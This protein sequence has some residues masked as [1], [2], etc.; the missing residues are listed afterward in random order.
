MMKLKW[1]LSTRVATAGFLTP[2]MGLLAIFVVFPI[3][4]TAWMSLHSGSMITSYSDMPWVGLKNYAVIFQQP[5]FRTALLNT[6]LYSLVS[7]LIIVPLSV[8]LGIFL[9]QSTI[10]GRGV[11][12][13]LLFIPYVIPNVAIAIVW[14]Y[15]YAPQYGPFNQILGWFHI[16][17]QDWL[18]SVH[19]A[20]FALIILNVWQTLGYYVVLVV[21]GLTEIPRDYYEAASIDGASWLQQQLRLT[22]PLL[23]RSLAFIVVILTINTLQVFDPVYVLTQGG[24]IDA[25]NVVAFNMYQTAFNFGHAGTASAMAMVLLAVVLLLSLAQLRLFRS[26]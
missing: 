1:R 17:A 12:R 8:I 4:L 11:L 14:G 24:P 21:A 19:Q 10:R 6:F 5:T 2:G 3:L 9:Y 13:T 7:L 23:K 20:L 18:A 16:P 25:T 22:I 26:I 15:L